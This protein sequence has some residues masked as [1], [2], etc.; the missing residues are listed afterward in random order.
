MPER[1]SPFVQ[2]ESLLWCFHCRQNQFIFERMGPPQGLIWSR[3]AKMGGSSHKP[4]DTEGPHALQPLPFGALG[5]SP[6]HLPRLWER[7]AED[8]NGRHK[9]HT[10]AGRGTQVLQRWSP[11]GK[12]Q[13]V[14]LPKC[15]PRPRALLPTSS[16]VA[17]R[18]FSSWIH[19][20]DEQRG[21]K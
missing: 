2:A 9:I 10:E 1:S 19:R 12:M 13:K 7:E 21:L 16:W 5:L 20:Q 18:S 11:R 15:V 8:P 6:S 4:L 3:R 17:S 14:Q